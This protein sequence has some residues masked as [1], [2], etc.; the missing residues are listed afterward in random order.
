MT[1]SQ[2]LKDTKDGQCVSLIKEVKNYSE[3]GYVLGTPWFRSF[4]VS[5]DY[6][7]EIIQV[8]VKGNATN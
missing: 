1:A 5:L 3:I 7:T 6:D 2:Y 8:Y 4:I